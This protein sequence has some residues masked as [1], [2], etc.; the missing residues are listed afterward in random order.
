[1]NQSIVV[2][3]LLACGLALVVGRF[4]TI[5]RRLQKLSRIDAKLDALLQHAGVTFDIYKDVP[6]DVA[7]ALHRGQRILAIKRLRE[8]TGVGLKE[9]KE[10]LDEVAR[11]GVA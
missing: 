1:M 4:T 2:A 10:Y 9:A 6:A 7:E 3:V 5:E 8:A 11:R